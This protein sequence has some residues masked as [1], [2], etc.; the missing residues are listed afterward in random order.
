[1]ILTLRISKLSPLLK[2]MDGPCGL[3]SG[4]IV[5]DVLELIELA[6]PCVTF[7]IE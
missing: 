2:V 3:P 5:F 6:V 1:M 7:R 4:L